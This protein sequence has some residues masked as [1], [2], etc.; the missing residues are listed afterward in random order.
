MKH[1]NNEVFLN[2]KD[3][4]ISIETCLLST[5]ANVAMDTKHFPI[6]MVM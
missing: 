6:T 4:L 3:K 1:D 2:H 5:T